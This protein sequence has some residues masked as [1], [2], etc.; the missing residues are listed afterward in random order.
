M[1]EP[2]KEIRGNIHMPPPGMKKNRHLP[3]HGVTTFGCLGLLWSLNGF[4]DPKDP[5]L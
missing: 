3:N 4:I 1:G 2:G 5:K